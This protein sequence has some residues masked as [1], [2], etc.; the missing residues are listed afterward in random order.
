MNSPPRVSLKMGCPVTSTCVEQNR[1]LVQFLSAAPTSAT[2]SLSPKFCLK[3]EL[4]KGLLEFH[5][6]LLWFEGTS[7]YF[8]SLI[9]RSRMWVTGPALVMI[10][11][12]FFFFSSPYCFGC[13][14]PVGRE[15]SFLSVYWGPAMWKASRS[16]R[17]IGLGEVACPVAV[18]G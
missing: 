3:L 11:G 2:S 9:I 1:G 15:L 13:G 14:V 12:F 5:G 6:N 7:L 8:P 16:Q 4:L 17:S 10:S 18:S